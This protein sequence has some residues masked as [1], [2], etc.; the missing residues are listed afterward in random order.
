ML[1]EFTMPSTHT[2]T[3]LTM[4]NL[5]HLATRK[6][7]LKKLKSILG[8]LDRFATWTTGEV[9][10]QMK[11]SAP[12]VPRKTRSHFGC[13]LDP[14]PSTAPRWGVSS[15]PDLHQPES[16]QKASLRPEFEERRSDIQFLQV[17]ESFRFGDLVLLVEFARIPNR[18]HR[19]TI[20]R[21]NIFGN[22]SKEKKQHEMETFWRGSI[23]KVPFA[24]KLCNVTISIT[25]KRTSK[26]SLGINPK[27]LHTWCCRQTLVSQP[28]SQKSST[29]W[30]PFTAHLTTK[31]SVQPVFF[32]VNIQKKTRFVTTRQLLLT[33]L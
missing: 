17:T 7:N 10:A 31:W 11:N 16:I 20:S 14:V 23:L 1:S 18:P 26:I 24:V 22:T 3:H 4:V 8:F 9:V 30:R 25:P 15:Q 21:K 27:G 28:I 13:G 5:R 19:W 12:K 2:H 29:M 6:L 32:A 33:H